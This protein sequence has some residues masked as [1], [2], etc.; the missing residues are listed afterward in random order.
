[1]LVHDCQTTSQEPRRISSR[2]NLALI[3]A[4]SSNVGLHAEDQT[5]PRPTTTS[6]LLRTSIS[7][8][9]VTVTI[10]AHFTAI[11]ALWHSQTPSYLRIC[12]DFRSLALTPSLGL[13]MPPSISPL[14]PPSAPPLS[15]IFQYYPTCA[16]NPLDTSTSTIEPTIASSRR[17]P[18][19]HPQTLSSSSSSSPTPPSQHPPPL[20]LPTPPSPRRLPNAALPTPPGF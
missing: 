10:C 8:F 19:S 18:F 17:T 9:W 20:L 12:L 3:D 2:S 4:L 11:C 7:G 5:N 1:M 16:P 6:D 15:T 13:S 14:L